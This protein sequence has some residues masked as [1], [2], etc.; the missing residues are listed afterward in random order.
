MRWLDGITDSM[1]V[2]LS[3]L[4]ESVMDREAWR[5]RKESDTTERLNWTELKTILCILLS[6][7]TQ[8]ALRKSSK[9]CSIFI[10]HLTKNCLLFWKII[11]SSGMLAQF[12]STIQ[13][14]SLATAFSTRLCVCESPSWPHHVF[15]C[16]CVLGF[17]HWNMCALYINIF[18]CCWL[19][20]HFYN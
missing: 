1:D 4:R 14:A 12:I 15:Q 18:C 3:E 8:K 13:S 2:S 5:G 19:L 10:W 7:I 9:T 17:T 16:V 20:S 6:K 11:L